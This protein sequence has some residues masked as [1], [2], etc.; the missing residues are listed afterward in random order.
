MFSLLWGIK[1]E[2][3]CTLY[4]KSWKKDDLGVKEAI[5]EYN[6]LPRTKNKIENLISLFNLKIGKII[7]IVKDLYI[8][9]INKIFI[10]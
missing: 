8:K 4:C 7:N 6:K 10:H 1:Q 9:I 5:N 2:T 3:F